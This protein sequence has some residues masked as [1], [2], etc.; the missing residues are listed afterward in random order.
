MH[1]L[2]CLSFLKRKQFRK[3]IEESDLVSRV[4]DFASKYANAKHN[5]GKVFTT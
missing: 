1:L 4:S 2:I 5:D 3:Q